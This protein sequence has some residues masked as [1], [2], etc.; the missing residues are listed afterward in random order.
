MNPDWCGS[1]GWSA[2]PQSKGSRVRFPGRAHAWVAGSVPSWGAYERP[3]IDVCLSHLCFSPSL[4]PSLPSSLK[5]NTVTPQSSAASVLLGF[6]PP[7]LQNWSQPCRIVAS[8]LSLR[9]LVAFGRENWS[10]GWALPRDSCESQ[11]HPARENAPSL[12]ACP[13][14]VGLGTLQEFQTEITMMLRYH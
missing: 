5:T 4:P 13:V 7:G 9:V 6:S 1:A 12:G 11:R 3:L 8:T 10:Q 2:I 14:L